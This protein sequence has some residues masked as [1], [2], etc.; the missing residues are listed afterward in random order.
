MYRKVLRLEP[1]HQAA[2]AELD[3]LAPPAEEEPQEEGGRLRSW[4]KGRS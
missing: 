4:F 1:E 3:R 2:R